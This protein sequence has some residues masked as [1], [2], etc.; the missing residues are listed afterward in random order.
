MKR[1]DARRV[2]LTDAELNIVTD[3]E[4]EVPLD[5][6][7]NRRDPAGWVTDRAA[8]YGVVVSQEFVDY[9]VNRMYGESVMGYDDPD[10][11]MTDL[12]KEDR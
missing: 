11:M 4:R 10:P 1:L 8:Q 6:K 2:E 12:P 7:V 9:L 5:D 3:A